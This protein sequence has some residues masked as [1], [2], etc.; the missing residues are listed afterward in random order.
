MRRPGFVSCS[1]AVL[2]HLRS[3]SFSP[4][5]FKIIFTYMGDF[6]RDDFRSKN[7]DSGW[8]SKKMDQNFFRPF[9]GGFSWRHRPD[10]LRNTRIEKV[11]QF[12]CI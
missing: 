8:I 10:S 1:L 9:F 12:Q 6:K 7:N 3:T 5:F 11:S 4:C 2:S